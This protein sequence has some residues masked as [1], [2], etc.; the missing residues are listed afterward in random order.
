[1]DLVAFRK[2]LQSLELYL[3]HRLCHIKLNYTISTF[4]KYNLKLEAIR[5]DPLS[6]KYSRFMLMFNEIYIINFSV[7]TVSLKEN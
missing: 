5:A 6:F 3:P 2:L 7:L 4:R 1:M